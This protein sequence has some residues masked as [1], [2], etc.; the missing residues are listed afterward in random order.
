MQDEISAIVGET[1][2]LTGSDTAKWSRD[3][4]GKYQ[5]TP[6]AVVRPANTAQVSEIMKLANRTNTPVVPI[7]G[8]T[9][10]A[11]GGHADGA[12]MLSVD[13]MNAIREVRASSRIAIVEAGAILADVHAAAEDH[14]M[15][16]PLFFGAKGSAMIG[17]V[18]STNAGGSN[19]LRYGNTRDLVL[20]IE[21]VLPNGEI[22]EIMSELHK[23]NS[24]YNLKHLLIGAEGTLGII[25]AAVLKLHPR[26]KA[27]ATA[28]VAAPSLPV[29]LDLLNRLQEA[30]GGC[31]EAFEYMPRHHIELH[32]QLHPSAREPFDEPHDINILVEV[33]AT[34]PRD[35][36]PADDGSIPVTNYLEQILGDMFEEGSLLDAV[37][38]Q[39]DTQRQEMWERREAA[40]EIA[41]SRSP[42]ISNDIALPLDKVATFLEIME[43]R[44]PELDP[45]ARAII[46]AHLGDGN[47]H[48]T[49]WPGSSD[50]DQH[51][52]IV[53]AAEDE[54]LKLGGSFSAE[55]GIGLS[56]LP[57]MRRRK[58]P[59]A[60]SAMKAIKSA[61]DP[62]NILNPGK[63]LP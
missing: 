18:L 21:A 19:V 59:V 40:A 56:K 50:P 5:Y 28:M 1:Y 39:N 47:I 55:H 43:T 6:L 54:V 15:I 35:A 22:M 52:M 63:L 23:D 25:T 30:T 62:N 14:E 9:G 7:S 42:V 33:G 48:Y 13:R 31:V 46:V 26:P 57:S 8:N 60:L 41:L 44:L 2:V 61:L 45:E 16:F 53:E 38:A 37:V 36:T 32:K 11:G 10:L 29:A 24:G 20:G 17:G 58:N 34:A 49:V 4:V 27:Y 3:F 51:D 12:I